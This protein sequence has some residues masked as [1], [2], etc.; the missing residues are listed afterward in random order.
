[1]RRSHLAAC[2]SCRRHVR[3]S[4]STCPF[5]SSALSD[6]FRATPARQAPRQRLTR[7]ALFA[8]GAGVALTPACSSESTS[9][10]PV[11][12]GKPIFCCIANPSYDGPIE[13]ET[14]GGGTPD[15]ADASLYD[16]GDASASDAASDASAD[17]DADLVGVM[18]DAA[19]GFPPDAF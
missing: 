15:A 9:G 10:S 7:S 16:A 13:P 17:A 6:V 14:D 1:M 12:A 8:L 18:P 19:Y 11:D 3:V 5:C 4:E 2:P